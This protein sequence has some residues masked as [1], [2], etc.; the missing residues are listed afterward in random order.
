M[1]KLADL[2]ALAADLRKRLKQVDQLTGRASERDRDTRRKRESR[3]ASKEVQVPACQ[4]PQRR[5]LLES[6]D[7]LWLR[8]YFADL[9][10]YPFTTQQLEMIST[11]RNAILYGGD[12]AIAAS[13]GV[14]RLGPGGDLEAGSWP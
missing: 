8:Y 1:A 7:T 9:F 6:D 11:I 2:K 5:T 10:W 12:Q 14:V 3:A 13:P 4:D